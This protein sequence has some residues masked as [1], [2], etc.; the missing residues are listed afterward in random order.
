MRMLVLVVVLM[1]LT[2]L[3]EKVHARRRR[4]PYTE[5]E[6]MAEYTKRGHTFPFPK[7]NPNTQGKNK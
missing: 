5:E 6:R 3:V 2:I 7:Y 1:T 4:A